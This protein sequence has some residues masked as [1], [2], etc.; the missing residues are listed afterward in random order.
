LCEKRLDSSRYKKWNDNMGGV[1]NL[2]KQLGEDITETVEEVCLIDEG[3]EEGNE[4]QEE[5]GP[6]D[7]MNTRR[8]WVRSSRECSG[9]SV[10]S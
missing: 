7:E 2:N 6:V 1:D 3:D 5:L 4:Y 9:R 10:F 8:N